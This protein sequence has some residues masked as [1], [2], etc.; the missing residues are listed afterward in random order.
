MPGWNH[1]HSTQR[2]GDDMDGST[3]RRIAIGGIIGTWVLGAA[4]LA[5]LLLLQGPTPAVVIA[6]STGTAALVAA[7]TAGVVALRREGLAR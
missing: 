4:I 2:N 6:M 5:V 1:F 7:T 3:R